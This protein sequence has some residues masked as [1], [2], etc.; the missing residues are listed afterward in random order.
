MAEKEISLTD[1][2]DCVVKNV[3][4]S[5]A[6]LTALLKDYPVVLNKSMLPHITSEKEK[7]W[8]ALKMKY[9][10]NTGKVISVNQLKKLLNNMKSSVKKKSDITMTGNRPINLLGWEKQFLELMKCDENPIF[11][12][13]PGG[14]VVG[15]N[16]GA[17]RVTEEIPTQSIQNIPRTPNVISNKVKKVKLSKETEETANL[18]TAEL[19]RLVLLEQLKLT[20]L[21]MKREE[22]LLNKLEQSE[23]VE[24]QERGV[25]VCDDTDGSLKDF[26]VF[27]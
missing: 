4:D 26:L 6:I 16:S 12:K 18:S 14:V 15:V 22:L 2:D 20:R 23:K 19:Q 24:Q 27:R 13:V 9:M 17:K 7:A 25:E 10:H 11:A 3:Y 1:D 8:A 5:R 21:Q